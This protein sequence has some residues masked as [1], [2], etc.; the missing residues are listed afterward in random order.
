MLE[1][2]KYNLVDDSMDQRITADNEG[3]FQHGLTF[4]VKVNI[5]KQKCTCLLNGSQFVVYLLPCNCIMSMTYASTD[6][7]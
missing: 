6:C 2:T 3:H 1:K 4:E 7:T 5:K